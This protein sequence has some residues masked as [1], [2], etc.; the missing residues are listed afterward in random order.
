M[1]F[2]ITVS[3]VV[4]F[5]F[6]LMIMVLS[7]FNIA[8]SQDISITDVNKLMVLD[9][10]LAALHI[11]YEDTRPFLKSRLALE[12]ANFLDPDG[13]LLTANDVKLLKRDLPDITS[14]SKLKIQLYLNATVGLM[15]NRIDS[16]GE[17]LATF[18]NMDFFER[19]SIFVQVRTDSLQFAP[20]FNELDNMWKQYVKLQVLQKSI[21]DSI[22]HTLDKK[23][24]N[25]ELN[26]EL[27]KVLEEQIC[28][29]ESKNADLYDMVMTNFLR[30]Y[31]KC[32]DPHSDYFSVNSKD[33]FLTSLSKDMYSTGLIFESTGSKFIITRII[34]FS[35]A[36]KYESI[37]NGDE[38]VAVQIEDKWVSLHC[39]SNDEISE[40]FLGSSFSILN[41]EIK[42]AADK[43][44]RTFQLKKNIIDNISNHIYKFLL[45]N[46]SLKIGYVL[47][48]SFYSDVISGLGSAGQDLA[49]ILLGLNSINLDGLVIDL[50]NNAGGSVQEAIDLSGFFIDY[51]PLFMT[52]NQVSNKGYLHK[53]TKR[54]RIFK[55]KVIF[56]VNT[57]SASASELVVS[58]MH[59]YPDQLVVGSPTFG[60]S[61]GQS[62]VPLSLPNS[63]EDFGMAKIT[64]SRMYNINGG[65]YQQ[66]GVQPDIE[67]PT[68]P[69][70]KI[71]GESS[72][73][74]ALKNKPIAKS[75]SPAQKRN[76][77]IS[78]LKKKSYKRL[79]TN[80]TLKKMT[81]TFDSLEKVITDG[82]HLSLNFYQFNNYGDKKKEFKESKPSFSIE[83]L[84]EDATY[85]S[86]SKL[87]EENSRKDP[88]LN[89]VFQIF[90]DWINN[91][92]N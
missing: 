2:S 57:F 77:P 85:Q 72:Y 43:S 78:T 91:N 19:D 31:A 49:I 11:T 1:I 65:S 36:S 26:L 63:K 52:T 37:E 13:L 86:T 82:I 81:L 12:F 40:L 79:E 25:I 14:H 90:E 69:T 80:Q 9:R 83:S 66:F 6:L 76:S 68:F 51:G 67:L 54:G 27:K 22:L 59:H 15:R 32:F 39:L 64:T 45:K 75:F 89:E 92:Q 20:D 38:I 24:I 16:L 21:S 33:R 47:L 17:K 29:M 44:Y 42:S 30:A 4:R 50:R 8:R 5:N 55:G 48:P 23:D 35:D 53:D 84:E 58:A 56:L 70:K 10:K 87:V 71:I 28:K 7:I 73:R 60:K 88:I 74:Y 18:Q 46:D 41:L 34:P 3:R 61:T 62:L